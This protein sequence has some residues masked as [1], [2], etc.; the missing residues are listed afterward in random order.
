MTSSLRRAFPFG[1]LAAALAACGQAPA[2]LP[3]R[4]GISPELQSQLG[5]I[6]GDVILQINN[7]RV[8]TA[9]EVA[10]VLGRLRGHGTIQIA[11]EGSRS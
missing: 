9:E 3:L 1:A 7:V 6:V 10:R 8:S 11:A 2:E 4:G 5:F